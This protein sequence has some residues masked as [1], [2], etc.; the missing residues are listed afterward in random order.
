MCLASSCLMWQK[1]NHNFKMF[2]IKTGHPLGI[3][4]HC[5]IQINLSNKLKPTEKHNNTLWD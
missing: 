4:Y 1:I 3:H 2:I 5:P